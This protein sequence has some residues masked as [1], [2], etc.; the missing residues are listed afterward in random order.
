MPTIGKPKRY[1]PFCGK[2]AK[3][4]EIAILRDGELRHT[5]PVTCT[6]RCAADWAIGQVM[7]LGEDETEYCAN[8]GGANFEAW[9]SEGRRCECSPML[10][11]EQ[12]YGE[13]VEQ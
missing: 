1:C 8:C 4:P 7:G 6:Q 11:D 2:P 9:A 12:D 13:G 10:E 5:L 3:W